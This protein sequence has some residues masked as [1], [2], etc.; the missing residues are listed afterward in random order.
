MTTGVGQSALAV[1]T[2]PNRGQRAGGCESTDAAIS[3]S[4][5][6]GPLV[7]SVA[8]GRDRFADHLPA[9]GLGFAVPINGALIIANV[10][11]TV[12]SSLP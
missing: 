10:K 9:Q 8:S 1:D 11:S 7:N 5:S 3:R 12:L 6:P 2:D 4:S